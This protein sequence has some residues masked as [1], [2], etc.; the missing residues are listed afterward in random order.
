MPRITIPND[1]TY[2]KLYTTRIIPHTHHTHRAHH[3]HHESENMTA[4]DALTDLRSRGLVLWLDERTDGLVPRLNPASKLTDADKALIA[5][6]RAELIAV[7]LEEARL[8][9]EQ[10]EAGYEP[11]CPWPAGTNHKEADHAKAEGS[12]EGERAA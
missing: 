6:H 7:L 8:A 10:R 1:A 4:I 5:A 11:R 3:A 9:A 12:G 2:Y